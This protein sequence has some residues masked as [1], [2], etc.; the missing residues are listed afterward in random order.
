M[1]ISKCLLVVVAAAHAA[2]AR[3]IFKLIHTHFQTKMTRFKISG[4][5]F[6]RSHILSLLLFNTSVM[7][8]TNHPK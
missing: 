1:I 4:S 3:F 2:V 7:K 8:N 5:N 6:K